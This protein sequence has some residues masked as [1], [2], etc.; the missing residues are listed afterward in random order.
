M[1]DFPW[2]NSFY[3]KSIFEPTEILLEDDRRIVPGEEPLGLEDA[4]RVI[5]SVR[6]QIA[7]IRCLDSVVVR[8]VAAGIFSSVFE[9]FEIFSGISSFFSVFKMNI[10]FLKIKQNFVEISQKISLLLFKRIWEVDLH[11]KWDEICAESTREHFRIWGTN[12]PLL[13]LV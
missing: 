3:P 7:R 1:F 8:R 10:I 12:H 9:N 11:H 4:F 6:L 13:F 5:V 2:K